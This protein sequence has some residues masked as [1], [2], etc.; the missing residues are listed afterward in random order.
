MYEGSLVFLRD[1]WNQGFD[2][3]QWMLWEYAGI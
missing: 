2:T 1:G 3:L